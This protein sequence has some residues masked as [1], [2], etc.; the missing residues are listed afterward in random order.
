MLPEGVVHWQK[1]ASHRWSERRT[2]DPVPW[3]PAGESSRI[4]QREQSA[5][6]SMAAYSLDPLAVFLVA[7][8]MVYRSCIAITLV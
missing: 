7:C 3:I 4:P 2:S 8:P 5:A 6:D 1:A